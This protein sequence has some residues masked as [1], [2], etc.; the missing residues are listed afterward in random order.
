MARSGASLKKLNTYASL[1]RSYC[2]LGDPFCASGN[3]FP[4]HTKYVE[5]YGANAVDFIVGLPRLGGA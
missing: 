3:D 4:V 1:I 2:D 5:K